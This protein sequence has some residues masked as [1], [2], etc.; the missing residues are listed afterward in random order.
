[1]EDSLTPLMALN[2]NIATLHAIILR[3][4]LLD[5]IR[6]ISDLLELPDG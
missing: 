6:H 3:S 5:G 4:D 1:M 2:I